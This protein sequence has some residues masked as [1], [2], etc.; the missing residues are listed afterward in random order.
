M[1]DGRTVQETDAKGRSA[2]EMAELWAFVKTRL[3]KSTKPRKDE[4]T[5]HHEQKTRRAVR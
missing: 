1:I 5:P 4:R 2:A 3:A